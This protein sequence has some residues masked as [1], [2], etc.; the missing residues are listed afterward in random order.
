MKL[1]AAVAAAVR[2]GAG[3][4]CEYCFMQQSLQGATFHLDH[5]VPRSK[6]GSLEVSDLALACPSCNLRKADRTM[7]IDP[8]GGAWV[9]LFHPGQQTWS[10]HFRFAGYRIEGLTA[11]GR[12]DGGIFGPQSPAT[13]AHPCC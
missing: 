2:A 6:G 9:P 8:Q 1:D 12:G 3:D 5:I 7:A 10:N 11:I 13:Q 4:R